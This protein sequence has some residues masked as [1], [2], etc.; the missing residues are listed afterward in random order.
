MLNKYASYSHSHTLM[1][2]SHNTSKLGFSVLPCSTTLKLHIS[3]TFNTSPTCWMCQGQANF[4]RVLANMKWFSFCCEF[5]SNFH[6]S[7]VRVSSFVA[8]CAYFW[9]KMKEIYWQPDAHQ[10]IQKPEGNRAFQTL[11][12]SEMSLTSLVEGAAM[13]H[14]DLLRRWFGRKTSIQLSFLLGGFSNMM[15][16]RCT[17]HRIGQSWNTTGFKWNA[18]RTGDMLVQQEVK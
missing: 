17:W 9:G 15:P 7:R 14:P 12:Q 4:K 3:F 2:A 1:A 13:A 6:Y 5:P 16:V 18:I 8:T 10:I 11:G